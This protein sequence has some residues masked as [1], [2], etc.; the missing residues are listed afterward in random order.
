MLKNRLFSML[1]VG[2]LVGFAACGGAEEGAD[3]GADIVT[4]DT[5]I[6]TDTMV[7]TTETT[8]DTTVTT[9]TTAIEGADTAQ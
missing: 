1:A 6:T 4:Q 5:L 7:A 9:D 8:I 3:E 2:A